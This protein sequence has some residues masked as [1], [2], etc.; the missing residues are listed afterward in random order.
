MESKSRDRLFLSATLHLVC[1][2]RAVHKSP[3]DTRIISGKLVKG[4]TNI[5]EGIFCC[6]AACVVVN[7]VFNSSSKYS[8]GGGGQPVLFHDKIYNNKFNKYIY[9]LTQI[10]QSL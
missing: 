9:G 5:V 3:Q 7:I 8:C 6:P 2:R 10:Q 4:N 1:G